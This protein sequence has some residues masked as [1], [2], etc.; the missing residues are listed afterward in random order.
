MEVTPGEAVGEDAAV[1]RDAEHPIQPEALVDRVGGGKRREFEARRRGIDQAAARRFAQGPSR[2]GF[3]TQDQAQAAIDFLAPEP[4]VEQGRAAVAS[5]AQAEDAVGHQGEG[6][7]TRRVAARR[8]AR[9]AHRMA[10]H[11][12]AT[13]HRQRPFAPAAA[14]F[15]IGIAVS[16]AR[17]GGLPRQFDVG[18]AG[19]GQCRQLVVLGKPCGEVLPTGED[20]G[21]E[22]AGRRSGSRRRRR[23]RRHGVCRRR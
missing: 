18:L 7:G 4:V 3:A 23:L 6:G 8:L 12:A 16:E 20:V 15:V 11:R 22:A 17:A 19:H 13:P 2:H 1:G 5:V 10:A 14:Q 21:D 9:L